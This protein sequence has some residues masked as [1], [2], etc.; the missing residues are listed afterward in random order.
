MFAQYLGR[1]LRAG[2]ATAAAIE[3]ASERSVM[4]QNGDLSLQM[5][6]R[7]FREGSLLRENSAGRLRF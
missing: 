2:H 4:R 6:R 7:Y 5:V 3:G 1:S